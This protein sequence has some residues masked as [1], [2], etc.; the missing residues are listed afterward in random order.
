MA[1]TRIKA[2]V[3][4]KTKTIHRSGMDQV[5]EWRIAAPFYLIE[6]DSRIG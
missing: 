3:R 1:E 5:K 2:A 6:P 4:E